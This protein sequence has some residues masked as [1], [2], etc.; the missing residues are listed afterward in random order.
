MREKAEKFV[1]KPE[2]LM[3]FDF[4]YLKAIAEYQFDRNV[5]DCLFP[6]KSLFSVQRSLNT[7]RIRNVLKDNILYLVLKAQDNLFSLTDSSSLTIKECTKIPEYRVVVPNDIAEVIR[8]GGNVFSKHVIQADKSLRA[9]DYVLVV[10]EEDQLIA[11]GKMKV[12]G[13][14]AIEYKKGVAVNVKGRIKNENNT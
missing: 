11:Y 8:K 6:E 7:W 14:E 10:N 5:A 1:T 13:E 4:I 12:S 2:S 3:D 9:G